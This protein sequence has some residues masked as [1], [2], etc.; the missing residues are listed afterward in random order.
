[1]ALTIPTGTSDSTVAIGN[2]SHGNISNTGTLTDTAAAAAGNDY[3]VIRDDTN[4]KIQTSTIKGTDVKDAVDK[5]HSHTS[6]TLTETAQA[7]DG[8]HTLA[9]T[10]GDTTHKGI[11]LLGAA[12]GAAT[13]E[14]VQ[15]LGSPMHWMGT[16]GTGGTSTTVPSSPSAGDTYKII[17]GG[18]T[19]AFP[20]I[21]DTIKV[22]DTVVYKDATTKW[23]LIPSGDEPGGTVTD[24]TVDE[25]LTV[26]TGDSNP[27]T[28]SGTIK[29]AVPTGA[30]VTSS[31]LY[32]ISTDKFGHVTSTS[33][34]TAS[35]IPALNYKP[36]QTAVSDPSASGTSITFID[37]ISQNT[38]GVITPTK[39]TIDIGTGASQVAAG[40]HT[41]GNISNTGTLQTSDVTIDNG[42][43]LVITDAS[44]SHKVARASLSFGAVS[45]ENKEKALSKEGT[46]QKYIPAITYEWN[47]ELSFG[48]SGKLCIGKFCTYDSN[49]TIDIDATTSGTYHGTLVIATQN[50]GNSSGGTIK[51]EVYGDQSGTIANSIYIYNHGANDALTEVYFSPQSWSKNVVHIRGVALRNTGSVSYST[52]YSDIMTSVTAIPAEATLKPTNKDVVPSAYCTTSAGTAAKSALLTGYAL[53]ANTYLQIVFT[54]T[55]TASTPTLNINGTGAKAM[56]INGTPSSSSNYS[57]PAGTYFVFYDGTRYHLRTDGAFPLYP[58]YVDASNNTNSASS[59][60]GSVLA[61]NEIASGDKLVILDQSTHQI[62]PLNLE[63]D[64]SDTTNSVLRK[65]GV[66]GQLSASEISGF[67][68]HTHP[69]TLPATDISLKF[70]GTSSNVTITGSTDNSASGSDAPAITGSVTIGTGTGTVNYTPAGSVTYT[71]TDLN[72]ILTSDQ[73]PTATEV[74]TSASLDTNSVIVSTQQKYMHVTATGG[75]SVTLSKPT[76]STATGD[77]AVITDTSSGTASSTSHTHNVTGNVTLSND[78]VNGTDV[79][80]IESWNRTIT[81]LSGVTDPEGVDTPYE[82]T[83]SSSAKYMKATFSNGSAAA[84]TET[85]VSVITSATKENLHATGSTPSVS[86]SSD[87]TSTNGVIFV[88]SGTSGNPTIN[89]TKAWTDT[90][91]SQPTLSRGTA[92]TT[93]TPSFSGT[94]VELVASHTLKLP[95]H[96]HGKGTLA[97]SVT[98]SG[99]ISTGGSTVTFQCVG[100]GSINTST[101]S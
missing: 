65:T 92:L 52:L 54:T 3:V 94:G 43:K 9:V 8:T 81:A 68:A 45:D 6:L 56:W 50:H 5:K 21:T 18:E 16:I 95:V 74:L 36:I 63:F 82:L 87:G 31:G 59:I 32:K 34:V 11:V 73:S 62:R 80:Y 14:A 76:G 97:G 25:G 70:T 67:G 89:T 64:T 83:F 19:L 10:E 23:V 100:P 58:A 98:P 1:M 57:I 4:N 41:H 26:G 86:L 35:D 96:S 49:L 91:A 88:E 84:S 37:S 51:A 15:A 30:T 53:K 17:S 46:W 40:N 42:D 69:V 24:I 48:S 29:H 101:P 28:S 22:G 66:F 60:S 27:I 90:F 79:A 99:S 44:D 38:D 2:H 61:S 47:K 78:G 12:G 85:G 20:G 72:N 7:Y 75:T 33:T 93:I 71:H 77:I 13:Y 55:N 39:K